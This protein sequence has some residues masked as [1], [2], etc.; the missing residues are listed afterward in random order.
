M[1]FP[2]LF[3]AI[4]PILFTGQDTSQFTKLP[5]PG[6]RYRM[7]MAMATSAP[8]ID[9]NIWRYIRN[10]K[11]N[12]LSDVREKNVALAMVE[13]FALAV[14]VQLQ[15]TPAQQKDFDETLAFLKQIPDG[16]TT[17]YT[18]FTL[19]DDASFPAGEVLNLLSR[20]NIQYRIDPQSTN[21]LG[22]KMPSPYEHVQQLRE[23]LGDDKRIFRLFGSEL[24]LAYLT[25]DG[26]RIRLHLINYGSR[27]VEHL[28]L[29]IQGVFNESQIKTH[30]YRTTAAR[31]QEFTH[32]AGYT[33]FTLTALP[34]YA[35][36]DF[37]L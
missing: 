9:S 14:P 18:D 7:N 6:V 33:E 15:T 37:T 32:E 1:T 17:P 29:R 3:A 23:K 28:R 12:Y 11:A 24:T 31:L 26:K 19:R 13:A 2:A 20:R 35:V 25:R 34:L 8:W 30:I 16:P 5:A 22:A 10:S 36:L 4:Y 21:I 27:P